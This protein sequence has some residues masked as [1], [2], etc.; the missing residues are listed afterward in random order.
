[1]IERLSLRLRIFLFFALV[2]LGGTAAVAGALAWGYVRLGEP[3]ALSAFVTSGLVAGFTLLVMSAGIW[4]LFDEHVAK[5]VERLASDM[6]SRAH[7]DVDGALDGSSAKYLGDLAPA[8]A[9]V[10]SGLAET[11]TAL[12]EAIARETA[13]IEENRARLEAILAEV[14]AGIILCT[15]DH[16]VAFYNGPARAL[17]P[18]GRLG[19]GRPLFSCLKPGPLRHAQK[20]L[21]DA[22]PGT[23]S[24]LLCVSEAGQILA[25]RMRLFSAGRQGGYLLSLRDVTAPLR[26]QLARDAALSGALEE[27]RRP[28]AGLQALL[29]VLDTDLPPEDRSRLLAAMAEETETLVGQITG[30]INRRMQEDRSGDW[31]PMPLIHAEDI[32]AGLAA[33]LGVP[34]T[35]EA[36]SLPCDGYALVQLATAL[37]R[38]LQES[39]RGDGLKAAL[40]RVAPGAALDLLWQGPPLSVTDLDAWLD[41]PFEAHL[42]GITG[43]R[44][45]DVHG[46]EAWPERAAGGGH[47]LRILLP[48]T[49]T[50]TEGGSGTEPKALPPAQADEPAAVYDF[51]L[52]TR[53]A[54]PD[55]AQ[56]PLRA[57][58]YVV[59]DTETTGLS[60]LKGDRI[61]QIAAV[62][63]VNGR[64]LQSERFNT[65]V[66][67]ERPIPPAATKIHHITDADVAHAPTLATA[68]KAFHDYCEGAVLVAHNAPFDI[69][70][71]RRDKAEFGAVF[72][73]PVLDTVLLSAVVFGQSAEHSLDALA[74]R[75]GVTI[76]PAL[77]HTAHGDAL[78]T[79]QVFLK[80][81]PMMEARGIR[82]FADATRKT[83]EHGRL[84]ADLN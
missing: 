64:I 47:R 40:S 38:R 29:E 2:G 13:T 78:A 43:R 68:G 84:L 67:P 58:P 48:R 24:D 27:M 33:G 31:W 83:R 62:R 19:L 65:L 17:F 28:A 26:N 42:P 75:L 39:G 37:G 56:S 21:Q 82:T 36:L 54:P 5:A 49:G 23:A 20:R 51:D 77:R 32:R 22:P 72:D 44:L 12:Q 7:A 55:I 61:V 45:L 60:V 52:I 25:G 79:A 10:A 63:I 1:M 59:F 71:L 80:L 81:L 4:L 35:A 53:P 76:P 69:G 66:N 8:A 3:E 46:A 14:E 74:E 30:L 6:R 50:E 9:A 73:H 16:E 57:L 18:E 15:A 34:A 70:M 41:A 11:K